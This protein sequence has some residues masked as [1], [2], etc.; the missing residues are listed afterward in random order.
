MPRPIEQF[1]DGIKTRSFVEQ[2]QSSSTDKSIS[3]IINNIGTIISGKNKKTGFENKKT[4]SVSLEAFTSGHSSPEYNYIM[5]NDINDDDNYGSLNIYDI[6]IP[7]NKYIQFY[8]ASL[9][10]LG[11]VVLYKLLKQNI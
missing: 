9:G 6:V 7:D 10:F 8:L 3:N 2:S 4:N 11:L 5:L 1:D